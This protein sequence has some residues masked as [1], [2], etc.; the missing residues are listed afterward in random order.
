MGGCLTHHPSN[1]ERHRLLATLF[2]NEPAPVLVPVVAPELP[3]LTVPLLWAAA[4]SRP[5]LSSPAASSCL[6][7][8]PGISNRSSLKDGLHRLP[9]RRRHQGAAGS[10]G[11]AISRAFPPHSWSPLSRVAW[12]FTQLVFPVGSSSD[13][14]CLTDRV[15]PK[16]K[17]I[18]P[19]I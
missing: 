9:I 8:D 5:P 13:W 1:R 17:R 11:L 12:I 19:T 14:F 4:T 15:T 3:P 6:G 2:S 18:L 7:P 10:P 16:L